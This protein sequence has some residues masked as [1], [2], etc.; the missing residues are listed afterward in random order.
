VVEGLL[1]LG[2][3]AGPLQHVPQLQVDEGEG[4]VD[5]PRL[6]EEADRLLQVAA[7]TVQL[8]ELGEGGDGVGV[9][10]DLE[11]PLHEPLRLRRVPLGAQDAGETEEG[12]GQGG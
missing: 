8:G 10:L 11:G 2:E 6:V 9:D 4:V 3:A 7:V 5:G 12:L 1:C